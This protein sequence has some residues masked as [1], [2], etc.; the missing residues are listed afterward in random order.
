MG[1]LSFRLALPSA[2]SSRILTQKLL[3]DKEERV[4]YVFTK[5]TSLESMRVGY[6][7]QTEF[8]IEWQTWTDGNGKH[9]STFCRKTRPETKNRVSTLTFR[10]LCVN[11][12]NTFSERRFMT[13]A[14]STD[15]GH[16]YVKDGVTLCCL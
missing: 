2:E 8:N 6:E 15:D 14:W 11:I 3:T 12:T 16:A 9:F 7:S 13:F 1:A 10:T 5:R 4:Y